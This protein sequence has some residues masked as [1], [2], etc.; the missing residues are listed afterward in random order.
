MGRMTLTTPPLWMIFRWQVGTC[1]GQ[2][3]CTKFEVGIY[4]CYGD[5]KSD[6]KFKNRGLGRLQVTQGHGQCHRWIKESVV[7]NLVVAMLMLG[8]NSSCIFAGATLPDPGLVLDAHAPESRPRYGNPVD[9]GQDCWLA[10][11]KD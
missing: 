9:L 3:T 7:V 2:P 11:R 1:Y 4:I 6:A 10:T 8:W 5:M